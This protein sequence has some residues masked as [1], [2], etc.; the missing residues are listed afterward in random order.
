[1]RGKDYFHP[2]FVL[3]NRSCCCFHWTSKRFR[4]ITKRI[5]KTSI[6]SCWRSYLGCCW[7]YQL[8][9]MLRFLHLQSILVL[10][11]LVHLMIII[12]QFVIPKIPSCWE[13]LITQRN[14]WE[15]VYPT[16][17]GAATQGWDTQQHYCFSSIHCYSK[18]ILNFNYLEKT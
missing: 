12:R 11:V 13:H 16:A 9:E 17:T 10:R 1:M 3:W 4:G 18:E 7:R 8:L 14:G 5:S 2:V 15:C 6:P